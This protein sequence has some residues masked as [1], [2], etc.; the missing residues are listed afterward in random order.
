MLILSDIAIV[1]AGHPFRGAIPTDPLG[2]VAVVLPRNLDADN[3]KID[4]KS[5]IRTNIESEDSPDWLLPE[6]IL[7]SPRSGQFISAVSVG[8]PPKALAAP[9]LFLVRLKPKH[10]PLLNPEFLAWQLNQALAQEHFA[11]NAEGGVIRNVR[12]A[13]LENTP[14]I[15][16]PLAKQTL[17]I[18]AHL[19]AMHEMDLMHSLIKSRKHE[20]Q[21]I[22]R[23]ILSFQ[24][25]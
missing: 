13:V 17:A 21:Q 19:C 14:V 15:T 4:W 16:P 1:K 23:Q 18:K 10:R 9:N 12:R 5:V 22:A 20:I 8:A 2:S 6:D 3:L 24:Q 7:F 11:R 25:N